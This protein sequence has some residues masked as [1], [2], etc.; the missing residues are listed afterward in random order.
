MNQKL[1]NKIDLTREKCPLCKSE[2]IQRFHCDK[3]R[4]YLSCDVCSLVFVPAVYFIS[5]PKEKQRYDTHQNSQ[6]DQ[7][8]RKFLNRTFLAMQKIIK[9]ES[10]GLD[11]GSGPGPTLSVMFEEVGH[12]MSIFDYFYA[13]DKSAFDKK[14]DFITATEVLEHLHHPQQELDRL[15]SCL[16]PGGKLGIMTKL[17]LNR[18]AFSAWHY[19]NDMTHVCFYSKSTFRW[20]AERWQAEIDLIDKD[21]IFFYKNTAQCKRNIG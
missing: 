14:Y 20:L 7:G 6:D 4:E 8:Y 21:V 2:N 17:V 11:F 16:K 9:P 13:K 1:E 10:S 18:Q 15:W 5:K 12:K 19:T 3:T